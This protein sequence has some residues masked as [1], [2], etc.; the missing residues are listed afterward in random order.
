MVIMTKTSRERANMTKKIDE[1][2]S[3]H[4]TS[5]NGE[6]NATTSVEAEDLAALALVLKNAGIAGN[7]EAF[8]GPATLNVTVQ[9]NG[10]TL[11]SSINSPDLRSIMNLLEP[12]FAAVGNVAEPEVDMGVDLEEFTVGDEGDGHDWFGPFSSHQEAT[13]DACSNISGGIGAEPQEGYNYTIKSKADGFYWSEYAPGLGEEADYDHRTHDVHPKPYAGIADRKLV[14]PDTKRVPARSGDNPLIEGPFDHMKGQFPDTEQGAIDFMK[15]MSDHDMDGATARPDPEVKNVWLV[16]H[17]NGRSIVYLNDLDF[18][19]VDESAAPKSFRD[20]VEEAS[21]KRSKTPKFGY[22]VYGVGYFGNSSREQEDHGEDVSAELGFD[23]GGDFGES[24]VSPDSLLDEFKLTELSND[25]KM[26]YLAKAQADKANHE[27]RASDL[28]D[29]SYDADHAS[30][31]GVM[32]PGAGDRVRK[33]RDQ[34]DRVAWKREKG[35][36]RIVGREPTDEE[37][38]NEISQ[39]VKDR[40]RAKAFKAKDDSDFAADFYNTHDDPEIRDPKLGSEYAR[41][42]SNRA[43]GISRSYPEEKPRRHEVKY[44]NATGYYDVID[45]HTGETVARQVANSGGAAMSI[46]ANWDY[47]AEK[48]MSEGDLEEA[49]PGLYRAGNR[50]RTVSDYERKSRQYG[51]PFYLN[52]DCGYAS[53]DDIGTHEYFGHG[54]VVVLSINRSGK[55]GLNY[56]AGS[57]NTPADTPVTCITQTSNGIKY[58]PGKVVDSFTMDEYHND[59]EGLEKRLAAHGITPTKKLSVKTFD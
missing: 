32:R 49:G 52:T 6:M 42:S 27:K 59:R 45:T 46:A 47:K 20:Y 21:S 38:V 43:K 44:D 2:V 16:T 26:N 33:W 40:Y 1:A 13:T 4:M 30:K 41:K 5:Q 12:H 10:S 24:E 18:E 23:F 31:M 34:H 57:D 14:Q 3:L 9:E 11:T 50:G 54:G 17:G 19:D 39:E 58:R 25:A 35:I 56:V 51:K 36:D 55:W 22:G 15:F 37:Q 8:N 29:L 7:S 28:E 53:L 48:A